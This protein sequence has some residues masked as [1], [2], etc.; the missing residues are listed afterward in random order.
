MR[1]PRASRPQDHRRGR[2]CHFAPNAIALGEPLGAEER[3]GAG[4]GLS[5]LIVIGEAGPAKK[6][7]GPLPIG[8][9]ERVDEVGNRVIGAGMR[10][11]GREI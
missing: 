6:E 10:F 8:V 4:H 1:P 5:F 2:L 9:A 3:V 7:S 11:G